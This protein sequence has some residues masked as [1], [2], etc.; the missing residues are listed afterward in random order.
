ML[1]AS[2]ADKKGNCYFTIL[3]MGLATAISKICFSA[4]D[5]WCPY[6]GY[7]TTEIV[8]YTVVGDRNY[9]V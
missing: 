1:D 7:F 4:K 9:I 3:Y 8:D 6:D 2:M 5:L